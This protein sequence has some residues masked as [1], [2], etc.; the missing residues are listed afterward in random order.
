M[1]PPPACLHSTQFCRGKC[2]GLTAI[3]LC[4]QYVYIT[5]SD[6]SLSVSSRHTPHWPHVVVPSLPSFLRYFRPLG[7]VCLSL[8][9]SSLLPCELCSLFTGHFLFSRSNWPNTRLSLTSKLE[10]QLG[11]LSQACN[12]QTQE[13]EAGGS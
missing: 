11:T 9:L 12:L 13:A 1:S 10:G 5:S 8:F 3:Q 7:F 2:L 4:L 6:A